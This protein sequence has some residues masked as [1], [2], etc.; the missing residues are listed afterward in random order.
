MKNIFYAASILVMSCSFANA[1]KQPLYKNKDAPV[2]KR[3]DDLIGQMTLEEK[4]MQMNQWTYGKNANP[5]NIDEQMKTVKPEIGSLLYRSTNPEYRNQIQKKA[6]NETRLGIPI[7]FGFDAIHG[8]KTIFPIP[9]AQAC[10]WNTDLVKQSSAITAKES[11]LSGLDWTFS[12]MVD[13]ARDARW[14]RISEGYGEDTYANSAFGVAAIQ[15]YQGNNLKDKYTIAA[16]LKHYI[17]YSMSEGGRDYHYSDIS[18]QTL[19]ESFLPPF[20]AGIKAGAATVMSGFNDISGVPASANHYTLTEILKKKWKHDG[21]VISDW[22]SVKNLVVQGVA[23]DTREAAEKALLAGVE[24][25]MVDNIYMDYLPE[26]V[27]SGKIKIQTIDEAVRRILRVKMNLGLFENPYV[28]VISEKDRYLLPD[29]LKVA[30]ELAQESM[31]LLK[32][33]NQVLPI[34]SKYKSIAAIG[35]MVKDSVHIMGFWEGMGD[36]KDVNTIFDGLTK[37]FDDQLKINYALGCDFEGED[38]SGFA[39]AV[40]V[41]NQ[42]DIILVFLGEKRN[43]SG[44]NGSRS[45]IALPKIQEDLVE[46]L[47]KTGKRVILVLSSGRPLELIRLN[48]MADAILEIWQPG[49][50]AGAAVSGILSGRHN[51]SGKLSATFPQT[52]GQIPIYYNMRQSARP[53]AGHYQDIP[54]DALYWFGHGLSYSKFEYGNIK[55]S[56][57]KFRKN[58]KIV[59]EIEI[60][61]KGTVDGKEAVL[62]YIN[63]PVANISRPMKELK[64]FEKKL[65]IAG[66]KEIYRFEINPEKDLTYVDSNGDKHLESGDFYII[67]GNKKTKF[68][69]ND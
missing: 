21:F 16:S 45:T 50:M 52:T 42:S 33:E 68:E 69:L 65:I 29:Y 41:A 40:E 34:T 23:K 46:E 64:F 39:K 24:M 3:I 26:L 31:V 22:G 8:Y 60:T 15:G 53:E 27:A 58:E 12:P 51:P 7:I 9:L 1:Q 48:K 44:E 14:G 67:V 59:A 47:S 17:G 54:R 66:K 30:E 4:I 62:W 43:W 13:V 18:Q 55:L 38:R 57:N 20:E 32:N 36:P 63:D 5:N 61:N 10:S 56:N 6:V 2:E 37:E 28:D 11:W 25:D 19:W 35:P 49:T